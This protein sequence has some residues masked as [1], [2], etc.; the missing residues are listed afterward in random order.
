MVVVLVLALYLRIFAKLVYDWYD[1]PDASHGF[2]IPLF[3]A[4]L[5]WE[6][7][8]VLRQLPPRSTWAGLWLVVPALALLLVGVLGADLFLSRL[9]FIVLACGLILT[10]FGYRILREV[11]FSLLV[12]L[13]AIPLPSLV[14]NEI[15]LPLQLFASAVSSWALSLT[16][17]PVL[18]DGNVIQLAS[19]KLEVAEACSG[20][21]SLISL[22]TVAILFGYLAERS[23][24]RRVIL[25]FASIPIA[26]IA[27]AIRIYGTGLCV[28]YW[29][30]EKAMGFFHEFSGWLMFLVSMSC[31][32]LLHVLMGAIPSRS[33][34]AR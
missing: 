3:S 22:L 32:Y 18:R 26:V 12:L 6:R 24:L 31:L 5:L 30:P 13:L 19:M 20:I 9:S 27:N 23:V 25:A 8:A 7:R 16:G 21:R 1:L 28:Q 11:R 15:T 29:D 33:V 14:L 2:L 34:G 10:L 4:F 17:V